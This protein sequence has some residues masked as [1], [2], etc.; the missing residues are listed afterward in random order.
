MDYW[1]ML[2]VAEEQVSSRR[3]RWLQPLLVLLPR[4]WQ[5]IS[6]RRKNKTGGGLDVS[7]VP[8]SAVRRKKLL[9]HSLFRR[10]K[11]Q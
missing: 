9:H 6:C 1:M 3:K 7:A 5:Q 10:K 8:K 2:T 4:M 11:K